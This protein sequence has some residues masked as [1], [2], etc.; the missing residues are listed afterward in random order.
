ME[1]G[2][3]TPS[4]AVRD[5]ARRLSWDLVDGLNVVPDPLAPEG[6]YPAG[7]A[8]A[9]AG[10]RGLAELARRGIATGG[11]STIAAPPCSIHV[12][13]SCQGARGNL[14]NTKE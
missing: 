12:A 9:D 3:G 11:I 13:W 5:F 2:D 4:A 6:G 8:P 10:E 14:G 7:A 1:L